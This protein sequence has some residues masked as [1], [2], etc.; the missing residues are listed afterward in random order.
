MLALSNAAHADNYYSATCGPSILSVGTYSKDR[1]VRVSVVYDHGAWRVVHTLSNGHVYERGVQYDLRDQTSSFNDGTTKP[2]W[3][4]VLRRNSSIS[5]TG[6]LGMRGATL[7]YD[8]TM[9]Q[10]GQTILA[11]EATCRLDGAPAPSYAPPPAAAPYAP[12]AAV[13]NPPAASTS[14]VVVPLNSASDARSQAVN[15]TVGST[16]VSMTIDSG[17]DTMALSPA[18]AEQLIAQG[19]ASMIGTVNLSLAAGQQQVGRRLIVHRVQIG[20]RVLTDVLANDGG[21]DDSMLLGQSVLGHFGR[22]SID[23]AAGQLVLGWE[24]STKQRRNWSPG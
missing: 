17:C 19:E 10:G 14:R 18:F 22:F 9:V 11:S 8:E 20:D 12:P 24:P 1:D 16:T 13:Y 2:T 7:T 3:T 15:V 6:S 23:R 5:M 21:A 4:G